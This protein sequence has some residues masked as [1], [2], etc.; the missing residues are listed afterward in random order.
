MPSIDR[1]AVLID[2]QEADL[3]DVLVLKGVPGT[4]L[5][6]TSGTKKL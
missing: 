6:D 1:K 3:L 4:E 5:L 2:Q